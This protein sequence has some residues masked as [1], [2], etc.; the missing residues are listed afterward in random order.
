MFICRRCIIILKKFD[1]RVP[2]KNDNTEINEMITDEK[3]RLIDEN[4]T[5]IGIVTSDE[6]L[7]L[8]NNKKLDLVKISPNAQPPVCKIMD[9]GKYRYEQH[10]REKE[11]R[12]NQKVIETKEIRLSLNIEDHDLETKVKSAIKFLKSGDKVKISLR[13]RGRELSNIDMAIDVVNKFNE[14]IGDIANVDVSP[15]LE[16]KSIVAVLSAK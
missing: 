13:L 5:Q 12:K 15:K 7:E 2:I 1:R 9:Y 16:G 6:A 14:K 11:N 8:A 4:G 3:V 10:K